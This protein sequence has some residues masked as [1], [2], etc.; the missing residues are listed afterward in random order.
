MDETISST[1]PANWQKV[2]ELEQELVNMIG[3]SE[4]S[5]EVLDPIPCLRSVAT[6]LQGKDFSCVMDLT[7]WLTPAIN[8]LFPNSTIENKFSL[9]RVRV[10]SSP[11]LETTGYRISMSPQE[12]E[13]RKK[14]LDLS[15]LLMID[16]VSF[17]GWTSRKTMEIWGI[18]PEQT[19]H[20]FLIANT[21]NLGLDAGAV[22]M[23][24]ALGSTV[25]FGH[26][27]KTP[28]EDG[29]HL[30]DLHQLHEGQNLE[31]SLILAMLFQEAV[32]NK[33]LESPFAQ[34]FFNHETVINT[35]FPYHFTSSQIIEDI[36]E[37][38]FIPRSNEPIKAN[39]IHAK[40]PF[41]WASP[42]FQKHINLQ[43]LQKNKME[44]TGLL[45]N[46]KRFTSDPEGKTE[47]G[48][49]LRNEVRNVKLNSPEGVL[50]RGKER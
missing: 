5:H 3:R 4:F 6:Q 36:K 14:G 12:I 47:A 18:K 15:R 50:N 39:Q 22:P 19:T 25:F 29:W 23:L 21:G 2:R 45:H 7:G 11:T 20:A 43:R 9:S 31:Q 32:L 26:E 38:K 17:T 40:N 8:E 10:V 16:D 49:E 37:G 33:G 42:Y 41:L 1:H 44:V 35:I 46:L 24:Q 34:E 30:K 48:L 28:E 27:I 13:E